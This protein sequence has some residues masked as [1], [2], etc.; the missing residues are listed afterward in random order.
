MHQPAEVKRLTDRLRERKQPAAEPDKR[1]PKPRQDL[2]KDKQKPPTTQDPPKAKDKPRTAQDLPKEVRE[3]IEA[4][5]REGK[6]APRDYREAI[7]R[8]TRTR[9]SPCWLC[10]WPGTRDSRGAGLCPI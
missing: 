4:I 8:I 3:Q 9:S 6:G 7:S 10:G 2:P 1:E 5:Y